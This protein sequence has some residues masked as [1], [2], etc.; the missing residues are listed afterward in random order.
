MGRGTLENGLEYLVLPAR[1]AAPEHTEVHLEVLA[2]SASELNH[3]QG[4]SI[5]IKPLYPM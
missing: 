4:I 1:S 5:G 2:G 3:Q